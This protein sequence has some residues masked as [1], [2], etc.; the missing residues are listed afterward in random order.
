MLLQSRGVLLALGVVLFPLVTPAMAHSPRTENQA[1]IQA[2]ATAIRDRGQARV[3]FN[4]LANRPDRA[5]AV[6]QPAARQARVPGRGS[7]ICSAAGFG[8]MSRCVER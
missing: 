2:A 6:A 7:Y 4:W 5:R 8:E 1:S 3:Q